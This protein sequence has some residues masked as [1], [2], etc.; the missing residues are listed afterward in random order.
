[1][2]GSDYGDRRQRTWG[3]GIFVPMKLQRSRL[4]ERQTERLLDSFV[5]A[6]PARLAAEL[7]RV[8]RNTA[9]LFYHRLREIIAQHLVRADP[10]QSEVEPDHIALAD[11]P[12]NEPSRHAPG[13]VPL[14]ALLRRGEKVHVVMVSGAQRVLSGTRPKALRHAHINHRHP[15][16][17][18]NGQRSN[19]HKQRVKIDALVYTA[20]PRLG[21]A[22]N[23]SDLRWVRAAKRGDAAR[24]LHHVDR[25]DDF[26]E[27]TKWHLR[28]FNGVPRQHF[29]LFVKECEWRYNYDGTLERLSRTLRHWIEE[30]ERTTQA[31]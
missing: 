23:V 8:N 14:F 5:A 18:P 9:R 6:T 17:R 1:M 25:I 10:V 2:L 31:V 13:E 4:S 16:H 27:Q 22:L 3:V 20:A 30:Q 19:H 28:R 15:D 29:Y 24:D 7:A 12:A 21:A 26:W 11:A